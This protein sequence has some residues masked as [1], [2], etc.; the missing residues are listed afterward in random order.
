MRQLYLFIVLLFTAA[1]TQQKTSNPLVGTWRVKY[2]PGKESM[3]RAEATYKKNGQYQ[4]KTIDTTANYIVDSVFGTYR[5]DSSDKLLIIT[6]KGKEY[7]QN[8][9]QLTDKEMTSFSRTTGLT[10]K[11]ARVK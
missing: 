1:C 8:I 11:L 4:F 9:L 10:T 7:K 6:Y 5:L 2:E 3:F